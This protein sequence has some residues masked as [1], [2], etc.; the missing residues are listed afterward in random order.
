MTAPAPSPAS[1]ELGVAELGR[2]AAAVLAGASTHVARAYRP[3]VYVTRA[4]GSRK[5]LDDGRELVDYTMGHGALLL[6]HCHPAV[7]EA[8]R[9]Q[10]ALGTHYGAAHELEVEWAERIRDLVPSAERV[11][12]TSSGTEATMLALRLAR[13]FTGRSVVVTLRDHFHGWHDAVSVLPGPTAPPGVPAEVARLTRVV[14]P[15]VPGALEVAL[16]DS[17]AAALILEGSGAHYGEVPLPEGFVAAARELCSRHG[18]LLVLDE[19]VTGF[20]VARGGMQ[21]LLG[22][23]PDLSAFAKVVAGGLPG[24]AVGGR[25]DVMAL[26]GLGEGGAAPV[27]THPGT[28]NANPLSAAAGC[29]A[30]ELVAGT[31]AVERAT[32][33]AAELEAGWTDRLRGTG[34]AG[35]VWRLASLVHSRLHDPAAQAR[36]GAL[37]REQGVDL[38]RTNAIVS[39]VHSDADIELTLG[40]LDRALPLAA[41]G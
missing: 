15:A 21:G 41:T 22:V 19:V 6:G 7:V 28:F 5:W 11:R 10:A 39:A 26:L 14:D 12:F 9:R 16:G 31:D 37:M 20:R 8:V 25:A 2:R 18:T 1:E 33:A 32:A 34:V 3:A 38:F 35:R 29:A 13:A 17:A 4:Q 30:L 24:G 23:R 27:V 40:A 36:L